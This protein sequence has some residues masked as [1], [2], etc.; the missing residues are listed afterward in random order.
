MKFDQ[1]NE[2]RI[3]QQKNASADINLP[4]CKL[5]RLAME[6]PPSFIGNTSTQSGSIFQPAI[7]VDPGVY[8]KNLPSQ[9]NK[10]HRLLQN[11]PT[12]K[13][14]LSIHPLRKMVIS[15]HLPTTQNP[16]KLPPTIIHQPTRYLD[17]PGSW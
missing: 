2:V 5:T 6:N 4:S 9:K 10:N 17:V 13:H 14:P 1:I 11:S 15:L 3:L 8:S 7:L 12:K 16:T